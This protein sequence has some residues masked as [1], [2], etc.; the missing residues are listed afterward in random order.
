MKIKLIFFLE[1]FLIG[2][3]PFNSNWINKVYGNKEL[4]K[5][6]KKT[7]LCSGTVLGNFKKIK[8]YLSLM[9]N[10]INNFKYKKKLKY[11][12]TFRVD[13]EGRGCDQGH[14]NFIVHNELID[15]VKFYTNSKGP[16][17]TAF[18]LKKIKFDKEFR[19]V[20][21]LNHPYLLVHQYDKRYDEFVGN[22]KQFKN[23]L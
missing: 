3:C 9:V 13:P 7:I 23:K 20:N 14:A 10:H 8:E 11:L 22:L 4:K 21:E 12:L 15:S 19:L 5:I 1:D 6:S 17:A 16:V 2:D 18:Y